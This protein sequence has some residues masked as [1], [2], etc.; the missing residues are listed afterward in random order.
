MVLMLVRRSD[1][2]IGSRLLLLFS[3]ILI[4]TLAVIGILD[5]LAMNERMAEQRRFFTAMRNSA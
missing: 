4:C 1:S 2:G 5:R 3:V